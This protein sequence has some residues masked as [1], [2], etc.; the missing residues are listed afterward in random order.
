[1]PPKLELAW[2]RVGVWSRVEGIHNGWGRSTEGGELQPRQKPGGGRVARVS[3]PALPTPYTLLPYDHHTWP[4]CQE[5]PHGEH[6]SR[7]A[8]FRLTDPCSRVHIS[9]L[10][11]TTTCGGGDRDPGDPGP[12]D[13]TMRPAASQRQH[14]SDTATLADVLWALPHDVLEASLWAQ[15]S[16]EEVHAF[17]LACQDANAACC[18]TRPRVKLC[19]ATLDPQE[20]Q[21]QLAALQR[22]SGLKEV[23]VDVSGLPGRHR[24][25]ALQRVVPLLH[26]GRDAASFAQR[27]E[28]CSVRFD[29]HQ[30]DPDFHDKWPLGQERLPARYCDVVDGWY[31][32][33]DEWYEEHEVRDGARLWCVGLHVLRTRP[34]GRARARQAGPRVG[35]YPWV[36]APS[37]HAAM[38]THPSSPGM[39][40]ALAVH[41]FCRYY[42]CRA[43]SGKT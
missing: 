9:S 14:D 17:K 32:D 39:H 26:A 7:I 40:P 4:S 35:G 38:Q 12:H 8:T 25:T 22:R 33:R 28:A 10:P 41:T 29:L 15:L 36:S 34:Q 27:V 6:A 3:S 5:E 30:P 16:A 19:A 20:L 21:Q 24:D 37:P 11:P 13:P 43:P 2:S 42:C 23:C 1:M 31:E 18:A